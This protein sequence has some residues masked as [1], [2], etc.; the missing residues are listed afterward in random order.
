MQ[1]NLIP[2][3]TRVASDVIESREISLES[4]LVSVI[5]NAFRVC[6]PSLADSM[7]D[8]LLTSTIVNADEDSQYDCIV[9]L[10]VTLNPVFDEL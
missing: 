2:F 3:N 4:C 7:H 9:S 10:D 8:P 5:V 6:S 1:L